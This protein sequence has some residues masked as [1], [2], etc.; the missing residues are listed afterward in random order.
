MPLG[1]G[2][3]AAGLAL[4]LAIAGMD[5]TLSCAAVA[6][7]IV[8]NKRRVLSIARQC[9]RFIEHGTGATLPRVDPARITVDRDYYG[10]A[11]GRATTGGN[12]AARWLLDAAGIAIDAT[13]SAKAFAAAMAHAA[14]DRTAGPTLFWLT[15]DARASIT[16]LERV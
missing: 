5:T 3:T 8:A 14:N 9:A 13:Y 12:D 10:G 1:S 15:Y 16:A 2:G 6:P 4:G 11:Y 7:R